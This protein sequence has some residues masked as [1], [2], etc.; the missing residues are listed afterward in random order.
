MLYAAS[1]H[2]FCVN[3]RSNLNCPRYITKY[4]VATRCSV[5]SSLPE[6]NNGAKVEYTPWLIVGLGNPGSKYDGTRHNVIICQYLELV[7]LVAFVSCCAGW[8]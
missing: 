6:N 7:A 2:S 5:R 3:Y 1:A 4:S 8:I